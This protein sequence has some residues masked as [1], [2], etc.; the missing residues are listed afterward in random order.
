MVGK[1]IKGA[2][3]IRRTKNRDIVHSQS[4]PESKKEGYGKRDFN[5]GD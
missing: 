4:D 1:C 5:Y 3:D 2:N